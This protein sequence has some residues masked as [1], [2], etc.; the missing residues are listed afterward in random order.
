MGTRLELQLL[1]DEVRRLRDEIK[2]KEVY[3]SGDVARYVSLELEPLRYDLDN[4]PYDVV[5][6]IHR[7]IRTGRFTRKDVIKFMQLEK[8]EN[9]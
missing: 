6:I 1:R 5:G 3:D 4:L 2:R 7:G 9:N 8:K